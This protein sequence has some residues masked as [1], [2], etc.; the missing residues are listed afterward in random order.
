[1]DP[2]ILNVKPDAFLDLLFGRCPPE[3]YLLIWQLAGKKSTWFQV[4]QLADAAEFA[5]ACQDDTYVGTCLSPRDFGPWN[6]CEADQMAV[7]V[8]VWA[9]IDVASDAHKKKALPETMD[10]ARELADSLGLTPTVSVDSGHGLQPYWLLD[11]PWIF[12]S[13]AE[14]QQ[15]QQLVERFQAALRRNALAA[16]WMLDATHD[17]ARVL[18]VPGTT[19]RKI[20]EHPVPV[21]LIDAGGPRY[22]RQVLAALVEP[23]PRT[24]TSTRCS[25]AERAQRYVSKMPP[26]ISHDGGHKATFNVAQVLVRGFALS[27]PEARPILQEYSQRCLP[28]WSDAELEHKLESAQAKSRL[29]SGYL[30]GS[31]GQHAAAHPSPR[32]PATPSAADALAAAESLALALLDVIRARPQL[33]LAWK[34][35]LADTEGGESCA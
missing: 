34:Q 6:R 5:A 32:E 9:D 19:N 17:L 13:D 16:G 7:L 14:R 29:P 26:A 18:R 23:A 11:E 15:A 4:S 12:P 2:H 35:A 3:A 25:T 24:R 30:L 8:G 20:K 33:R 21:Q 10:Q 1:M 31:N 22:D 27:V 28:P